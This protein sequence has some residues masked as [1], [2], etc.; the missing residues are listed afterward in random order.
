ME[1]SAVRA[2][3]RAE[4]IKKR[5][6][7]TDQA[8]E[9]GARLSSLAHLLKEVLPAP[10]ATIAAYRAFGSEVSLDSFM[11]AHPEWQWCCPKVA[12]QRLD[13]YKV[14][15][16]QEFT[17]S[18]WGVPEPNPSASE[19]VSLHHCQAVLVPGVVFDCKGHRLGY[20][21]GF[22][23]R[24]L[25]TYSGLKIGVCYS[26]QVVSEEL[27]SMEHDVRMDAVVTEKFIFKTVEG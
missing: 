27:Q 10:P 12:D 21:K 26:V 9:L 7:F 25:A 20:G 19:P 4:Y 3:L 18:N 24:A 22:Y 16:W 23:D 6:E 13:F 11:S 14:K 15:S 8:E 5:D 17:T 1:L 2:H